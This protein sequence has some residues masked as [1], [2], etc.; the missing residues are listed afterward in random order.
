MA[1]HYLPPVTDR[2]QV[3][4]G[5]GTRMKRSCA[6]PERYGTPDRKSIEAGL[7]LAPGSPAPGIALPGIALPWI[8]RPRI[9][10]LGSPPLDRRPGTPSGDLGPNSAH[11]SA[12]DRGLVDHQGVGRAL[13]AR[14]S[15]RW[16]ICRRK[17]R[18]RRW[19][20][21]P[22]DLPSTSEPQMAHLRISAAEPPS[23]MLPRWQVG[24]ASRRW[25]RD[26][27]GSFASV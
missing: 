23:W 10:R 25:V 2:D 11:S 12:E 9:A 18:A 4:P 1:R 5:C 14:L 22:T 13:D 24:R 19:A 16:L 8:A 15:R 3:M 27:A 7:A 6:W 21:N 20:S 26:A 17:S